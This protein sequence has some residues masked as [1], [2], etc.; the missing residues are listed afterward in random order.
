VMA[1]ET[2]FDARHPFWYPIA[3][4][5]W[6]KF[7]ESDKFSDNLDSLTSIQECAASTVCFVMIQPSTVFVFVAS[8]TQQTFKDY[9]EVIATIQSWQSRTA[10][11]SSLHSMSLIWLRGYAPAGS[12]NTFG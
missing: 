7:L 10:L 9:F 3:I 1:E 12:S 2:P 8:V 11:P 6:L 4:C 5:L